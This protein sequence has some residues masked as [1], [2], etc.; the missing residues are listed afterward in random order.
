MSHTSIDPRRATLGGTPALQRR[1][2]K[3]YRPRQ[4]PAEDFAALDR[5]AR[6]LCRAVFPEID[7][8]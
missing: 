3:K 8:A 2:F 5:R 4:R 7:F 1:A 6:A